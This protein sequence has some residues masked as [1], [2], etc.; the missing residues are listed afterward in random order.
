M[1]KLQ[2]IGALIALSLMNTTHAGD[3]AVDLQNEYKAARGE[4]VT[5]MPAS[6]TLATAQD[7]L[8]AFLIAQDA[9]ILRDAPGEIEARTPF[10]VDT[11]GGGSFQ[12]AIMEGMSAANGHVWFKRRVLRLS[13]DAGAPVVIAWCNKTLEK[14]VAGARVPARVS[15]KSS[16]AEW[17]MLR[18]I[19]A[20][21]SQDDAS[22][23]M[24]SN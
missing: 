23:G 4:I 5:T 18:E 19:T 1:S 22:P 3:S 9:E 20:E 17:K 14:N 12:S 7:R 21:L 6:V 24:A 15:C 16:F 8:R 13:Q 11:A 10:A 2:T